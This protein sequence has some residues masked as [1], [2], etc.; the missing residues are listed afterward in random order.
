[1][2][3]GL[4]AYPTLRLFAD[5][6]KFGSDYS[7]HR[8]IV[9]FTDYLATVEK[10]YLQDHGKVDF[11]DIV[12]RQIHEERGGILPK[13]RLRRSMKKEWIE[14]DHPGCQ[15]SGFLLLDRVPG[16]FHIQA[17]S[18]TH[19]LV[20]S[21]TNVSHEVHHLSFG[22]PYL[23]R[24]VERY[25]YSGTPKHLARKLSPMDG[26]V[27]V[28]HNLHEAHHHHLKVVPTNFDD[29]GNRRMIYQVL[30]QSQLAYIPED[31]VPEAQ[32]QYDLSPIA[33]TYETK[34]RKWY[35]YLTSLMAIIGG[36]FTVVGM[37][38]SSIYIV[39]RKKRF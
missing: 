27:Y 23:R 21:M 19:D 3:Q 12:A 36:T 28:T 14:E 7:G 10:Q 9:D 37:L 18:T 35:D 6:E 34:T 31:F 25:S 20:P 15:L 24:R 4:R 17:R 1:M 2:E 16:K 32:F 5:G 39:A 22:E 8:T 11:S 26:N 38:E 13:D 30:Q 33:V 29:K